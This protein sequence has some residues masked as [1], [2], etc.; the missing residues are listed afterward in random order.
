MGELFGFNDWCLQN[1]SEGLK[2][3]WLLHYADR[4]CHPKIY[5]VTLSLS[6]ST[7]SWMSEQASVSL[8]LSSLAKLILLLSSW[9]CSRNSCSVTG[10]SRMV[11]QAGHCQTNWLLTLKP[12]SAGFSCHLPDHGFRHH[13]LIHQ[14]AE[15]AADRLPVLQP[16]VHADGLLLQSVDL[17]ADRGQVALEATQHA[18]HALSGKG[19]QQRP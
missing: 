14:L 1:N 13:Q 10:L 12:R 19:A 6:R 7:M 18:L 11:L 17:A 2:A 16:D 4:C 5:M 3:L 9:S 8:K 15:V